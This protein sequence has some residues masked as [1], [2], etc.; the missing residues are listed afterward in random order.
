MSSTG[1]MFNR[2]S[3]RYDFLN[4]FFSLGLDRRWRKKLVDGLARENPRYILDIATGT[5]DLAIAACRIKPVKITGV[6]V[7]EDML[8]I[9]RKKVAEKGLGHLVELLPGNSENLPFDEGRFDAAM[10]SFGV[11]NFDNLLRGL[12]EIR[13]ILRDGGSIHILEFALPSRFPLRQL[14]LFYFRNIMPFLG[15]WISGDRSAYA[16]LPASVMRF[17]TGYHFTRI[18]EEAGF[19]D[20]SFR[21]LSSGIVMLYRGVK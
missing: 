19:H 21:K 5:G 10:V 8:A 1:E 17:P 16:Y 18:M 7:A 14:Y 4:H 3:G 2:I 20:N 13:R 6:D 12:Q 11:R 15:R 9:G